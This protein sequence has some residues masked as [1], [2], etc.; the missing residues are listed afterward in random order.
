MAV[1]LFALAACG[2]P[3]R[4]RPRLAVAVPLSGSLAADGEGIVRAVRLA[5]EQSHAAVEVEPVDDRGDPAAAADAA[6]RLAADARVFAVI[7]HLTSGCALAASRVYGPA[8]LAMITPTAT[9]TELTLQQAG[10]DWRGPRVV[11]RL[12][13]SDAVQ[14]AYAAQFAFSRFGLRRMWVL[15]DATPYGRGLADQFAAH[16][17]RRGGRVAGRDSFARGSRDFSAQIGRLLASGADGVF[18]G[19]DYLDAAVF[20]KQARREGARA[21]FLAGDGAK[22]DDLFSLAGPAVQGAYFTVGGVP[23]EDLPSAGD[24]LTAYRQAYPGARP[25]TFD[26]YGYEAAKIALLALK[27]AGPD[28][29]KVLEALRQTDYD[30]MIGRIVFDGDGDSLKSLVTM[31]RADYARRAFEPVY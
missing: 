29:A 18:F 27:R 12:P 2:G 6:R 15:D 26:D 3:A 28:R 7:G 17:Q 24:F 11:F 25:R 31:T 20:L 19:G 4:P 5:A 1:S 30:G 14:G 16:F 21:V 23:V 9:A 13:P 8:G 10:P 22:S